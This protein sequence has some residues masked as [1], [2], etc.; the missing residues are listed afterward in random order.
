MPITL[1]ATTASENG[2]TPSDCRRD[3]TIPSASYPSESRTLNSKSAWPKNQGL[4]RV[5]LVDH[6]QGH[7]ERIC[8]CLRFHALEVD[9]CP[10]PERAITRLRRESANYEVVIL[11]VSEIFWPWLKTLARLQGVCLQSRA[12]PSPLFLC[13]SSTKRSP[14]F[15]LRVERM[16]ARYVFEG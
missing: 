10:D 6:D 15:E 13:T 12:Y 2:A 7:A 16:G 3:I 5:L 4:L 1:R 11:N 9:V 8:Q 14:E